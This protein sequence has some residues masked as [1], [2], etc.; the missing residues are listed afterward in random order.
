MGRSEITGAQ[1]R[2]A[3]AFLRWTISDLAT[4]ANVG[5]STVQSVER[6]DGNPANVSEK[7]IETTRDYRA[8][9]RAESL[10]RICQAL[11][12]AGVTFLPDDGSTG[13]GLRCKRK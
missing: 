8:D 3:R 2:A 7:G 4:N 1:I 6:A 5:I 9:S 13:E 12:N 10:R 11:T